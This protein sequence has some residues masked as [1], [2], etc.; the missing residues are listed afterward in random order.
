M[1]YTVQHRS[2][3]RLSKLER[4]GKKKRKQH[5]CIDCGRSNHSVLNSIVAVHGLN[6]D[7]IKTWT[8]EPHGVCW[9]SHPDFLPKYVKRARVLV[10]G[11]NAKISSLTG[12]TA[13]S[14]RILQ[15][16]QTLVAQLQADRDVS[17]GIRKENSR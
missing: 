12:R 14:D 17:V 4:K 16:A 9:L 8:S 10:W 6:G 2:Q 15:H 3:Q 11:Y 13:S 5:Q 1:N 7:A